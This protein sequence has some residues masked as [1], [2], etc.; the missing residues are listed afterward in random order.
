MNLRLITTKRMLVAEG[1][2]AR[3]SRHFNYNFFGVRGRYDNMTRTGSYVNSLEPGTGFFVHESDSHSYRHHVQHHKNK[4]RQ[5]LWTFLLGKEPNYDKVIS[6]TEKT[7]GKSLNDEQKA[8]LSNYLN[9]V[10]MAKD[11]ELMERI[12]RG[13]K[14]KI[15]KHRDDKSLTSIL[16]RYKSRIATMQ[17]DVPGVQLNLSNLLTAEQLEEWKQV[18]DAFM[19][20]STCRRVWN[21]LSDRDDTSYQQ[22]F[23]D[24]GIFDF[25]QSP[26]DTPVMRDVDNIHYYLYPQGLIKARNNWDFE[27][28]PLE[29]L[30]CTFSVV[31]LN[32]LDSMPVFSKGSSRKK[33]KHS[34]HS[35]AMS[36]LY[37]TTSKSMTVGQL[38]FPH[39]NLTFY[40]N[41]TQ[42]VEKFVKALFAFKNKGYNLKFSNLG[43][44]KR[45]INN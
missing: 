13:V 31:D 40:C 14:D 35:D 26:F 25:I 8:I 11:V 18:T 28:I 29:N 34:H 30:E 9:V 27:V 1:V 16:T 42:P 45:T 7:F 21:V 32:A 24:M 10:N 2:H 36:A 38:Y 41:H 12:V 20:I 23:F 33:K 39:L 15:K 5:S 6:R 17:K 19:E 43:G 44:G 3:V 4:L 37:G 22:V